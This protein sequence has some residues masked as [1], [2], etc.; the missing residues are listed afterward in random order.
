MAD[1]RKRRFRLWPWRE[2]AAV[3]EIMATPPTA[4][5]FSQKIT[6]LIHLERGIAALYYYRPDE[7]LASCAETLCQRVRA[8]SRS[9]AGVDREVRNTE[10]AFESWQAVTAMWCSE[11][12]QPGEI[13]ATFG[14]RMIEVLRSQNEIWGVIVDP[15]A[16]F[17]GLAVAPDDQQRY[18]LVLVV[19]Q[20]GPG[21]GIDTATAAR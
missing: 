1:L 4:P 13:L 16:Q 8:E 20:K 21:G 9:A 3:S 2:N 6:E 15:R 18:W 11:V 12:W 14:Y 19:G 17:Y 5:E 10:A 7:T